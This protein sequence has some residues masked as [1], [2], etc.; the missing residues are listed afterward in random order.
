MTHVES[1]KEKMDVRRIMRMNKSLAAFVDPTRYHH[2]T[3]KVSVKPK[4]DGHNET[5]LKNERSPLGTFVEHERTERWGQRDV[6]TSGKIEEGIKEDT[7][8]ITKEDSDRR[9]HSAISDQSKPS[10]S[11]DSGSPTPV[12]EEAHDYKSIFSRAANLIKGSLLLEHGGGVMFFDTELPSAYKVSKPRGPP[13]TWSATPAKHKL[14][15]GESLYIPGSRTLSD[16]SQC[17]D[18]N[19]HGCCVVLA[20][21]YCPEREGSARETRNSGQPNCSAIPARRL[22]KFVKRSPQGRMWHYPE[23]HSS[24]GPESENCTEPRRNS[25]ELELKRLFS[26]L[27][28]ARAIALYTFLEYALITLGCVPSLHTF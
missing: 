28:G 9:R 27:P 18:D 19:S 2:R 8:F 12:P 3:S 23:L 13:G 21:S 26:H 15:P 25:E 16:S 11:S 6:V 7:A 10:F 14:A 5:G 4:K 24:S 1:T 20:S 17:E 22:M